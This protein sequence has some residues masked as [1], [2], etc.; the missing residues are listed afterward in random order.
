L[1]P[2]AYVGRGKIGKVAHKGN[3]LYGIGSSKPP[4]PADEE[5][6]VKLLLH[7]GSSRL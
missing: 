3:E 7:V 4:E 6:G 2:K 5:I 1:K